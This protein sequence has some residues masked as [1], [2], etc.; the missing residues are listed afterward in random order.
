MGWE[1]GSHGA[2]A[3]IASPGLS[4][5]SPLS[6]QQGSPGPDSSSEAGPQDSAGPIRTRTSSKGDTGMLVEN[7]K[8]RKL[9]LSSSVLGELGGGS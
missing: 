7:L 6:L 3:T 1:V 2:L 5:L 9:S 4:L 8:F